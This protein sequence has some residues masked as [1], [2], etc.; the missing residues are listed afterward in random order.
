[1]KNFFLIPSLFLLMSCSNDKD[2]SGNNKSFVKLNIQTT[3]DLTDIHFYDNNNGVVSGTYGYLAKTS[4]A[5]KTWT[6]LNT[7]V[8]HSFLSAFMLNPNTFFTA[9]L[10][11]YGSTNGGNTFSQLGNLEDYSDSIFA[12]HF[13]NAQKGIIVKGRLILATEDGGTNWTIVNDQS[14]VALDNLQFVSSTVGYAAGGITYDGYSVGEIYK[15][16]DGGLTWNRLNGD[17]VGSEITS[18]Y[19]VDA[20]VG[21]YFNFDN[22]LFKTTDGGLTWNEVIDD[23]NEYSTSM[24]FVDTN[25]GYSTTFDGRIIKTIDGGVHWTEMYNNTD[26]SL[27]KIIK[28]QNN[29]IFAVG[30]EGSILKKLN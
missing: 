17:T 3:N 16:T 27:I 24:V 15:T 2:S 11:I 9:R 20:S 13:F 21:F 18:M 14:E 23:N 30:N 12:I 1:M 4:N 6:Q 10:G 28:T 5:G 8:D 22:Q 7:P 25:I 29:T 19:F 26:V